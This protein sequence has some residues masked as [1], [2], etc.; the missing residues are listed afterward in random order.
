MNC[1]TALLHIASERETGLEAGTRSDLEA[2]VAACDSCRRARSNLAAALEAWRAEAT[3]VPTPDPSREWQA[4]RR[5]I[6]GAPEAHSRRTA[7]HRWFNPAWL[8]IPAA[9]AL[10]AL[11]FFRP[12]AGP[13]DVAGG[14]AGAT[15]RAEAVEAPGGNAS[16]MVFIDDK[17]GWLIVWAI[18]ASG[19]SG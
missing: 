1:R 16:T 13:E 6:R 14:K 10:V 11:T 9:A 12:A 19:R 8:A 5:R 15:A 3:L 4:F 7:T 18:D 2:H 17:S